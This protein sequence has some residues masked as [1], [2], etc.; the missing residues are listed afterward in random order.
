MWGE[1]ARIMYTSLPFLVIY[2]EFQLKLQV[3][4]F[5]PF[6]LYPDTE[7]ADAVRSIVDENSVGLT[8]NV[9]SPSLSKLAG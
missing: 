7:L 9:S 5:H 4:S 3:F 8:R 2:Q 6:L 1:N